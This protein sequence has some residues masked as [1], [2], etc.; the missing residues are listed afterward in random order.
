[1]HCGPK[2]WKFYHGTKFETA[3]P[4]LETVD[5]SMQAHDEY[6]NEKEFLSQCRQEAQ[7]RLQRRRAERETLEK[8]GLWVVQPRPKTDYHP[9]LNTWGDLDNLPP[10][11]LD[12]I[13]TPYILKKDK[14]AV[15]QILTKIENEDRMQA[16]SANY[17][18]SRRVS[19]IEA[20]NKRRAYNDMIEQLAG[21]P[22]RVNSPPTEPRK[23]A[24]TTRIDEM[25]KPR[26]GSVV[27]GKS[28]HDRRTKAALTG[29]FKGL[30]LA[31]HESA[32]TK[33]VTRTAPERRRFYQNDPNVRGMEIID[34]FAAPLFKDKRWVTEKPDPPV[35]EAANTFKPNVVF[36]AD[37]KDTAIPSS[38]IKHAQKCVD[39][40]LYPLEVKGA[41]LQE[42]LDRIKSTSTPDTEAFPL[43]SNMFP[44]SQSVLT[45][46]AEE[47]EE[48]RKKAM[49]D[50]TMNPEERMKNAQNEC[51]TQQLRDTSPVGKTSRGKSYNLPYACDTALVIEKGASSIHTKPSIAEHLRSSSHIINENHPPLSVLKSQIL[52]AD[53]RVRTDA[54]RKEKLMGGTQQEQMQAVVRDLDTFEAQIATMTRDHRLGN[55]FMYGPFINGSAATRKKAK[56]QTTPGVPT[57]MVNPHRKSP[58]IFG[59]SNENASMISFNGAKLTTSNG[60]VESV[61]KEDSSNL[62]FTIPAVRPSSPKFF[63]KPLSL[64]QIPDKPDHFDIRNRFS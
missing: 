49:S 6:E 61:G 54:R 32:V 48:R 26:S 62:E 20:R 18:A 22:G 56:P 58:Q 25:S 9:Y 52:Q 13:I 17:L 36:A 4:L 7:F 8:S 1:M 33:L 40:A 21:Q 63:S 43:H 31:D 42:I 35:F 27:T 44:T 14:E 39:E 24:T 46:F 2:T 3:S 59:G 60:G 47:E 57:N 55:D 15:V 50:F 23:F 10:Q 41:G 38:F 53:T 28:I 45:V 19:L 30:I 11:A 16:A 5:K 29:D 51:K 37:F 64:S 12:K 34:G